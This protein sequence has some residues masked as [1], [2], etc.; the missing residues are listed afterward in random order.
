MTSSGQGPTTPRV[1]AYVIATPA[2]DERERLPELLADLDAQELPPAL[3][4]LVDDHSTDGTAEWAAEAAASRDWME[5]A[6]SPDRSDEYLGHHI[7]RLKSWGLAEALRRIRERGVE[8]VAAGIVDADLRL[9]PD[10]Y[11]RLVGALAGDPGLG[12]VSSVIRVAGEPLEP[13]QRS[14]LPRGGTQTFRVD[15]LDRIGGLPPYAGFDG[16]ANVKARQAGF[17]TRLLP[18]V[19]ATHAR[20]TGT[21]YGVA[22]GYAR[23]G[24]YAWFLGLHPAIVAGRSVAYTLRAPHTGG[25]HFLRGWLGSARRRADRCPDAEVRDYYGRERL[26]EY[27]GGRFRFL[28]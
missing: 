21:R 2:R 22:A 8:P 17:E 25:V 14:D 12:V 16:A 4:L 6:S 1:S 26:R 18:D 27:L 9:P 13:F 11:A 7:G 28:R 3:W 20:E 24:E 5:V 19:E 23:K 10:H 15:C